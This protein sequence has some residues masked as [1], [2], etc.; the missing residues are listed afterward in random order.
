MMDKM[1]V[2]CP[3]CGTNLAKSGNGTNTELSC[4]K[5]S[6]LLAYEITGNLLILEVIKAST[7]T[8][9]V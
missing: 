3:V 8:K 1:Y 7:K 6:S 9:K 2:N 5:C 4:K